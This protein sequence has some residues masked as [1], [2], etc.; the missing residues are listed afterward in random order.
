MADRKRKKQRLKMRKTPP[1]ERSF[2]AY[3]WCEKP[4]ISSPG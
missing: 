2:P 4:Y 3:A 1:Y